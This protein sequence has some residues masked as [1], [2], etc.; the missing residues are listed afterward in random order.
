MVFTQLVYNSTSWSL[1]PFVLLW[2]LIVKLFEA[3]L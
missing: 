2:L 3:N 1:C